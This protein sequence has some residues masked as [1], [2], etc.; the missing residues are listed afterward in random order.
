MQRK[1]G[2]HRKGELGTPPAFPGGLRGTGFML[3]ALEPSPLPRPALGFKSKQFMGH[4]QK[5]ALESF[6]WLV[7][8]GEGG[9]PLAGSSGWKDAEAVL[10]WLGLRGSG[11]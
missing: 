11:W 6:F 1:C 9:G 7:T 10:S 8:S 3:L 5:C 2:K 4:S